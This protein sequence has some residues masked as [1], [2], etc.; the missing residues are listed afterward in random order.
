[1][2]EIQSIKRH[3]GIA[4]QV[5]Y[6][7]RVRYPDE[8]PHDVTFVSSIYGGP[9]VMCTGDLQVFVDRAVKDRIGST[10]NPEWVR[11]FFGEG[12]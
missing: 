8:A 9:I 1:M 12:E 7:A 3:M 4:G 2:I 5:A 10:L 6:T 11:K